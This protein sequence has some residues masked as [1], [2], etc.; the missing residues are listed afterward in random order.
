MSAFTG[1]ITFLGEVIAEGEL[2]FGGGG[3]SWNTENLMTF[4]T[5]RYA[6]EPVPETIT[7][8]ISAA[9]TLTGPFP[10]CDVVVIGTTTK[11]NS[12]ADQIDQKDNSRRQSATSI[13]ESITVN[14][15]TGM[16]S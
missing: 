2:F 7:F 5:E 13:G 12:A 14:P 3:M 8:N 16:F 1:S 9:W 11:A 4:A 6:P 10:D 15:R